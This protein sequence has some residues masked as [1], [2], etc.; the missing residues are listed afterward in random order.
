VVQLQKY[1]NAASKAFGQTFKGILD[2]Y[3]SKK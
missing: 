1:V 2:T 3:K